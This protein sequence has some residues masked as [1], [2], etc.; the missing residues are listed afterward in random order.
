MEELTQGKEQ[1]PV[2]KT[3]EEQE[4]KDNSGKSAPDH[5]GTPKPRRPWRNQPTNRGEKAGTHYQQ[6]REAQRTWRQNE[7]ASREETIMRK[8][9]KAR[10]AAPPRTDR[11]DGEAKENGS[12][13]NQEKA[14][15]QKGDG[16]AP[17]RVRRTQ[18]TKPQ[19]SLGQTG[20]ETRRRSVGHRKGMREPGITA[21][22][23]TRGLENSSRLTQAGDRRTGRPE[24][25]ERKPA[26]YGG[27][28]KPPQETDTRGKPRWER[29]RMHPRR[30]LRQDHEAE[31]T[32]LV[33]RKAR[34]HENLERGAQDEPTG[35]ATEKTRVEESPYRRN[36]RQE[37]VEQQ[38]GRR[39][40]ERRARME[41]S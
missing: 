21:A 18:P 28:E 33:W 6:K 13:H 32:T 34:L 1:P 22:E 41:G 38:R 7:R 29:R 2:R 12:D 17:P 23:R 15:E 35:K 25:Q 4:R 16:G 24:E 27:P 26:T 14:D 19:E 31:E 40:A 11:R 20:T 37:T 9:R 39:E 8:R 3:P 30:P 36:P 5:G 10:R